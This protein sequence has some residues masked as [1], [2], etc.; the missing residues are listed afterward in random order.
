M[1]GKEHGGGWS[2]TDKQLREIVGDH[3]LLARAAADVVRKNPGELSPFW[4]AKFLWDVLYGNGAPFIEVRHLLGPLSPSN[5]VHCDFAMLAVYV[6][7]LDKY[8]VV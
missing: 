4:L 7:D 6:L 1:Y 5:F 2:W 8:R 3:E